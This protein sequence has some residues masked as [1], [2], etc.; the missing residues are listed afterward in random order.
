MNTTQVRV[1][2]LFLIMRRLS[3]LGILKPDGLG[4]CVLAVAPAR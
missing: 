2:L 1:W 3:A 4:E